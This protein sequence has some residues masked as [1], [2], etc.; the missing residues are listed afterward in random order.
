[1]RPCAAKK[2]VEQLGDSRVIN[3]VS[4]LSFFRRGH[5]TPPGYRYIIFS[6]SSVEKWS[7]RPD[8][9]R[10][11]RTSV[12]FRS[13]VISPRRVTKLPEKVEA[14]YSRPITSTQLICSFLVYLESFL[15]GPIGTFTS[16]Y[17]RQLPLV[18]QGCVLLL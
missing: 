16:S 7:T 5:A 15:H 4:L 18:V 3:S 10:T 9:S 6:T 11:L 8:R 1:M 17:R 12:R 13:F 14:R 2:K